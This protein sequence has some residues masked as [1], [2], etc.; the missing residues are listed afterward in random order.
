MG[1]IYVCVR[2]AAYDQSTHQS[3]CMGVYDAHMIGKGYVLNTISVSSH[4]KE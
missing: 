3:A 1:L 4:S 2:P